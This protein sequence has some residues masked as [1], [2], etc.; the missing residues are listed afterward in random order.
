M[1][2]PHSTLRPLPRPRELGARAPGTRAYGV[3]AARVS[4][5]SSR[6]DRCERWVVR[7]RRRIHRP[8][9]LDDTE[10]A[11]LTARQGFR[12]RSHAVARDGS[13]Q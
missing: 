12:L 6:H 3:F 10:F 8:L 1:G 4:T 5:E 9:P 7:H 11:S 13:D 2:R